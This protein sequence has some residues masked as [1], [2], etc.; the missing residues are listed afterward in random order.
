MARLIAMPKDYVEDASIV[1]KRHATRLI[2]E[3]R[4]DGRPFIVGKFISHD[5]RLQFGNYVHSHAL[6]T[7]HGFR[8]QADF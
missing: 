8:Y 7:E 5:S 1:H 2:R 3:Q 4:L 6:N